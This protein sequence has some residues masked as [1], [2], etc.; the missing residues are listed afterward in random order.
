MTT[1][2]QGSGNGNRK[3]A[4]PRDRPLSPTLLARIFH[5]PAMVY[6]SEVAKNQSVRESARRLN[7]ASSAVSRQIT[8]LEDA[9][10]MALFQRNGRALKLTAAGEILHRHV[11]QISAPLESA[12]SELDMLRGLQT[13]SVR[14]ATVESVCQS[15]LPPLLADFTRQYPKLHIDV[16]VTSSAG[17]AA[18]LL[19]EHV[20]IGLG[21]LSKPARGLQ[22]T[23]G[24]NVHIG[25]LMRPDHPLA[26]AG[27]LTLSG[28]LA[29]PLA[30]GK[31]ELSV[32]RAIDALLEQSSTP[33]Q[34]LLEVGSIQ[35]LIE[36]ALLGHH[37]SI[38]TSVGAES[39][40]A[41]GKLIFRLLEDPGQITL[42]F[43]LMKRT[44]SDFHFAPAVFYE[45]AQAYFI[46]AE[47][48]G[49]TGTVQSPESNT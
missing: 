42:R 38:S 18:L 29:H 21:F 25:A 4:R 13:G 20:D 12:I 31:Q 3:A 44:R 45:Q 36:L 17:V 46:E 34:P 33:G 28:C 19:E 47:L 7:V 9:L 11:R 49:A 43:G 22:M 30:V 40:I 2:S 14:I 16:S 1:L 15:F 23:V 8:Q 24:R 48:P 26:T 39:E 37:V 41:K 32:R 6:F 35:M 27:R 10:G 5:Q